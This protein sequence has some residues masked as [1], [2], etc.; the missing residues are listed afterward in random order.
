MLS[1][2]ESTRLK[3]QLS[4]KAL[5]FLHSNLC[6]VPRETKVPAYVCPKLECA[7]TVW[8]LNLINQVYDPFPPESIKHQSCDSQLYHI[9]PE[10]MVL[11]SLWNWPSS[12]YKRLEVP[13]S[14]LSFSCSFEIFHKVLQM[15]KFSLVFCAISD[16]FLTHCFQNSQLTL[17]HKFLHCFWFSPLRPHVRWLCTLFYPLSDVWSNI[18]GLITK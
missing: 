18:R 10:I 2:L 1:G 6:P 3:F 4:S 17:S 5:V 16:N 9:W 8:V 12:S 7:V 13:S 15:R 11:S 14:L